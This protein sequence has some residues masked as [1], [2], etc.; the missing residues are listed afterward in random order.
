MTFKLD[1]VNE[2]YFLFIYYRLILFARV[3]LFATTKR[4]ICKQCTFILTTHSKGDRGERVLLWF[5]QDRRKITLPGFQ[6]LLYLL[7]HFTNLIGLGLYWIRRLHEGLS[8]LLPSL[9]FYFLYFVSSISSALLGITSASRGIRPRI[10]IECSKSAWIDR[11]TGLPSF[12]GIMFESRR[13][14]R[15]SIRNL[16][17]FLSLF[18]IYVRI[19][20]SSYF[21]THPVANS[22]HSFRDDSFAQR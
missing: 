6:A 19:L 12:T 9:L 7:F 22:A 3:T 15:K 14:G 5:T 1:R 8:A 2:F 16:F 10:F 4:T 18:E 21:A 20:D 13:W 17:A 11:E